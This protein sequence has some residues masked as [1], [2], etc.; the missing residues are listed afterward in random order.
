MMDETQE[1]RLE[2]YRIEGAVDFIGGIIKGAKE[3]D[4]A[5]LLL[6]AENA[7][8]ALRCLRVDKATLRAANAKLTAEII[9]STD[10]YNSLAED[11]FS[12]NEEVDS[13]R[14]A[15]AALEAEV[16]RLRNAR[17]AAPNTLSEQIQGSKNEK[18]D[19]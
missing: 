13:L 2:R 6:C 8:K 4:D 16:E 1:D 3:H 18:P 17:T 9:E 14:S 12:Q 15:N 7:E 19:C 10:A 11:A 5:G